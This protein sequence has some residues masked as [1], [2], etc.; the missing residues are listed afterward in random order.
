[1]AQDVTDGGERVTHLTPNTSYYAHLSIYQFALPYCQDGLVLDAGSGAGYGAAYVAAHGARQVEGIDASVKAVEFSQKHFQRDNLRYQMMGLESIT[2]FPAHSFDLIFTSNTL[3][4]VADVLAFLHSAWSLVKPQGVVVVAVP[5]VYHA[6][7]KAANVANP[8]H[9]NIWSPRQWH[10]TIGQYF[11]AV[12]CVRHHFEKPGYVLDFA[13]TPQS[14]H[15][16]EDD[17]LFLPSS[18]DE[19]CRIGAITAMF[20]ASQPRAANEVPALGRPVEFV[21]DSFSRAPVQSS[22][23]RLANVRAW[24]RR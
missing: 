21:D 3:E 7:S 16:R 11:A 18:V 1:M 15:L 24:L 23:R 8:Y 12:E 20:V 22:R 14:C 19:L 17:F 5:P 6:E 4:H 9:L 2:G 10:A 13:D